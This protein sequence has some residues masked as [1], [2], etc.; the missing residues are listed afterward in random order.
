MDQNLQITIPEFLTVDQYM[1]MN[2]YKGDSLAGKMLYSISAITGY[3]LEKVKKWPVSTI[4]EIG[5]DLQSVASHNNEFYTVIEWEDTL[6]GYAHIRQASLGEYIDLENYCKDPD[7]NLHKIAAILY[8][9]ITENRFKNLKYTIRQSIKMAKG[10]VENPFDYYDIETYDS[11]ER[12]KREELFK[13]FPIHIL[14]GALAFFL[15]N[16]SL[17][18]NHIVSLEKNLSK[19]TRMRLEKKIMESLLP[20]IGD[21]SRLFTTFPR[22]GFYT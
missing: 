1:K 9:P 20:T 7:N 22:P 6:Y 19:M 21:G 18:L 4:H 17:Y 3:E 10:K 12:K 5:K 11:K 14:L 16:A 2:Q 15:T 13:H 8:R